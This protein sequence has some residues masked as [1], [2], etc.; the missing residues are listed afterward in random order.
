MMVRITYF[1]LGVLT[2]LTTYVLVTMPEA[3]AEPRMQ[4]LIP[5]VRVEEPAPAEPASLIPAG[6]KKVQAMVTAYCPC[7]KCCGSHADGKTATMTDASTPGAAVAWGAIPRRSRIHIPGYGWTVADDT[8]GA[9]RQ[10]WRRGVIHV[11]VRFPTHAEAR[12]W[13]VRR[14]DILIP[15]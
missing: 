14:L 4:N 2:T 15:E 3:S 12:E 10:S 13:G 5:D 8:G 9:M 1:V 7:A 6:Y 11:D